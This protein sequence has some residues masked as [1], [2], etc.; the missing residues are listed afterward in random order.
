MAGDDFAAQIEREPDMTVVALTGEIDL[1]N[2][3]DLAKALDDA[4]GRGVP[5]IIDVSA[6]A[7]I[8]S[9]GFA[10]IHR[11]IVGTDGPSS[12]LVVPSA[13]PTA[14]SFGVSGL[15]EVLAVHESLADARASVGQR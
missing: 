5:V 3:D 10:A 11:S 8:D 12:H 14:R 7:F 15:T 13:C 1:A 4:A 2:V 6:L 9:A